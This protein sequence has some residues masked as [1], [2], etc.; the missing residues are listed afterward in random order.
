MPHQSARRERFPDVHNHLHH[1]FTAFMGLP[2]SPQN[3]SSRSKR[4]LQCGQVNAFTVAAGA[5]FGGAFGGGA[6]AAGPR[7]PCSW[8]FT[9][10]T[11]AITVAS[12]FCRSFLD[13]KSV[14]EGKI[15]DLG[16]GLS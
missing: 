7:P 1:A 16:G 9:R 13:R 10:S 4:A 8:S 5:A 14:V 2:H 15:G 12:S 11:S 3:F 6:G